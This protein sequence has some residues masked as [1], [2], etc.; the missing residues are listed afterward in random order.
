[1]HIKMQCIEHPGNVYTTSI[2]SVTC[3]FPMSASCGGGDGEREEER[4]YAMLGLEANH[5]YSV[6]DVKQ[7]GSERYALESV[8]I[9]FNF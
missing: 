8:Y 3:R 9:N 5:A 4:V 1:M 7:I 6:L 2:W